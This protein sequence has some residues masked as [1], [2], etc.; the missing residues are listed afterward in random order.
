MTDRWRII[1][2][3]AL[4]ELAKLEPGSVGAII[5]DP[6]YASTSDASSAVTGKT[7]APIPR[8]TQFFEAW[9]REM[10][11]AW[12]RVLRP[13]GAAWLT[14]DWRGAMCLDAVCSR[15]GLLPVE[16]GV[17]DKGGLGQGYT[18]RRTYE[19]FCVVRMPQF[20]RIR[21]DEPDVWRVFWP[22]GLKTHHAAE[23][24]VA[25]LDRALALVSRPGALILDPFMGSGSTGVAALRTGRR[26][27]GIERDDGY[28]RVARERLAAEAAQSKL[29]ITE[30]PPEPERIAGSLFSEHEP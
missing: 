25:L 21:T 27:V 26:F 28:C 16:V 11:A 22:A 12:A 18:L 29:A 1:H 17:W 19:C 24:P 7:H 13:D 20:K 4:A 8:E 30:P 5:T 3:D 9:L 10:L 23:K 15:L 6:P 2:G 14:L